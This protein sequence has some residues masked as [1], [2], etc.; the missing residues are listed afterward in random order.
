[1]Y[2][3][4]DLMKYVLAFT[5]P[6]LVGICRRPDWSQKWERGIVYASADASGHSIMV[7]LESLDVWGLSKLSSL[8][9]VTQPRLIRPQLVSRW[10]ACYCPHGSP[11]LSSRH[12]AALSATSVILWMAL[13]FSTWTKPKLLRALDKN[14]PA[15]LW[16]LTSFGCSAD[17]RWSDPHTRR[18][19]FQR[20]LPICELQQDDLLTELSSRTMYGLKVV[21]AIWLGNFSFHS[22]SINSSVSFEV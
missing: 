7:F 10:L 16:H 1:M 9:Q 3:E 21:V 15:K 6:W 22:R 8:L 13:C 4:E 11:L 20:T 18:V 5:L 19:F 12:L 2:A 14:W 17:S